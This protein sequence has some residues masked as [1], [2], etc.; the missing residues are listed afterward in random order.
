MSN[1]DFITYYVWPDGFY[2]EADDVDDRDFQGRSD[3]F[4]A[5]DIPIALG[6]EAIEWLEDGMPDPRPEGVV[7]R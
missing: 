3:D 2:V 5:V 6:D 1:P 7:V 4:N